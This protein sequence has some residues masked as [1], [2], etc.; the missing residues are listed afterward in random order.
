MPKK[1]KQSG[2]ASTYF[3]NKKKRFYPRKFKNKV[4]KV[5]KQ[6]EETRQIVNVYNGIVLCPD[7]NNPSTTAGYKAWAQQSFFDHVI[8][9]DNTKWIKSAADITTSMDLRNGL[10]VQPTFAKW[11]FRLKMTWTN[12]LTA[13]PPNPPSQMVRV[14]VMR[15]AAGYALADLVAYLG[16]YIGG[17]DSDGYLDPRNVR[18]MKQ[19]RIVLSYYNAEKVFT[20]KMRMKGDVTFQTGNSLAPKWDYVM[21]WETANNAQ[22]IGTTFVTID[23]Q[24][25]VYFK[26]L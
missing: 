25:T 23:G 16:T 8:P 21:L 26:D 22:P 3:R 5:L 18:V 14:T 15:P 17:A 10:K 6:I 19:K 11:K 4:K 7:P 9:G 13:V 2:K 20:M 24:Q 12:T 1:F